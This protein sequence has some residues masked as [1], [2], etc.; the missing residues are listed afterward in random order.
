MIGTKDYTSVGRPFVETAK[1]F[2]TVEEESRTEKVIIFKKQ[3]REGYQR[4]KG[5]R[6]NIMC[7]RI[8][9]IVHELGEEQAS[10]YEVLKN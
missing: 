9:N 6:Q 8:D 3:R 4:N 5:H 7:I 1:V 10:N 2:A